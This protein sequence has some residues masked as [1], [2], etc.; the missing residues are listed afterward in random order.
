MAPTMPSSAYPSSDTAWCL[1]GCG[2]DVH[3][4]RADGAGGHRA[5]VRQGD[6]FGDMIRIAGF[7][8]D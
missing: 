6:D 7:P 2:A 1:P 8:G 4:R 3:G 5:Q